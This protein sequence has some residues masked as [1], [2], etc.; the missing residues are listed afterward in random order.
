MSLHI[1]YFH[2][3]KYLCYVSTN[4]INDYHASVAPCYELKLKKKKKKREKLKR[5]QY[6]KGKS[7]TSNSVV[8]VRVATDTHPFV[9]FQKPPLLTFIKVYCNVK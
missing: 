6:L 4:S 9:E 8:S 7:D 2:F 1:Y 3:A 5:I